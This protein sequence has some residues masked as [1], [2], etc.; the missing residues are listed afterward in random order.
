[1]FEE[2]HKNQRVQLAFGLILGV[3]FGFCLQK[4]NVTSYDVIIG[5]LLLTDF[6]VLKL[7][8]SAVIVGMILLHIMKYLGWIEFHTFQGSI[9]STVIGGC[10]F[11]LGFAIL[12]LCPGTLVGAIGAGNMDALFGGAVG[13][14]IGA[15]LFAHYFPLINARFMDKGV[16]PA[17]TIPELV[18][19]PS[20]IVVLILVIFMSGFLFILEYF[21]L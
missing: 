16:F 3:G 7:M 14:L 11:G 5:Q 21:R 9:G 8:L 4:G 6:T 12:G 2:L 1:M 19:I 17:E 18:G 20:W 13:M 10:L 15:G